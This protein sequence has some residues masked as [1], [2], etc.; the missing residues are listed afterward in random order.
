MSR[1]TRGWRTVA[2]VAILG[3]GAA[4]SK[5]PHCPELT[6]DH[7]RAI[8]AIVVDLVEGRIGEQEALE[9][10]K[11]VIPAHCHPAM[12]DRQ[13]SEEAGDPR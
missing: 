12:V 7:E 11:R 8:G 3:L 9:R 13:V 2:C 10:M 1:R 5:T 6:E 4:A